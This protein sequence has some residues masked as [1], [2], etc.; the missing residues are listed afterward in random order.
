MTKN[1]E[2]QGLTVLSHGGRTDPMGSQQVGCPAVKGGTEQGGEK[3]SGGWGG[4]GQ[5][6]HTWFVKKIL[7]FHCH[8][9]VPNHCVNM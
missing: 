7:Y 4:E 8:D 2:A 9:S 3:S 5:M 6:Q 1:W